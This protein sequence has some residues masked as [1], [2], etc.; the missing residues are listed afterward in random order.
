MWIKYDV[1]DCNF[2]INQRF[3]IIDDEDLDMIFS[4]TEMTNEND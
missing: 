1:R 3:N 2:M 4:L